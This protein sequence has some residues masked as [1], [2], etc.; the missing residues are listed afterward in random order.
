MPLQLSDTSLY[1]IM[2]YMITLI[3]TRSKLKVEVH[4]IVGYKP[5][6]TGLKQQSKGTKDLVLKMF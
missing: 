4:I 1:L 5:T 3:S 2:Q 6:H